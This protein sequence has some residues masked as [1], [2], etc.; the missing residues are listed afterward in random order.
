MNRR[1]Q[2]AAHSS[3]AQLST[4]LKGSKGFAVASLLIAMI[5]HWMTSKKKYIQETY[6]AG[7][8]NA[9]LQTAKTKKKAGIQFPAIL[10]L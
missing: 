7:I 5:P 2:M 1:W 4:I 10:V 6:S 8:E 3:A 9:T